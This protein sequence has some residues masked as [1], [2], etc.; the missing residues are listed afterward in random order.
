MQLTNV[1]LA[2][3]AGQM[4]SAAVLPTSVAT[5]TSV[6]MIEARDAQPSN[7]VDVFNAYLCSQGKCPAAAN[8]WA[9]LLPYG[10]ASAALAPLASA[11]APQPAAP[12]PSPKTTAPP[13]Q[14]ANSSPRTHSTSLYVCHT[15]PNSNGYGCGK[16]VP[17]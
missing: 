16:P 15:F 2:V 3:L 5:V 9:P 12:A 13:A 8:R 11:P 10:R 4:V 1:L 7:A 6:N 14:P 17:N